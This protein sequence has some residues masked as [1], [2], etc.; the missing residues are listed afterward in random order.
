VP[1]F[2]SADVARSRGGGRTAGTLEKHRRN[3]LSAC[4]PTGA[5]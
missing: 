1:D 2:Q 5:Y 4:S 3:T